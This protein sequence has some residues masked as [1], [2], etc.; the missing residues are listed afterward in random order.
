MHSDNAIEALTDRE[1]LDKLT[2]AD[3]HLEQL[4]HEVRR[5]IQHRAKADLR[6]EQHA[7]VSRMIAHLDQ[8]KVDWHTVREFF[9]DSIVEGRWPDNQ[10]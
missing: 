10:D 6:W 8:I 1:L 3:L 5:R 9:R 4:Q 7:E 2:D